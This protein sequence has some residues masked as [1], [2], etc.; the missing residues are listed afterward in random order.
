M[1]VFVG[2]RMH[3]TIAAFS[4]GV[5]TIPIA[6]SRKFEGLFGSLGYNHVIDITKLNT[7]QAFETIIREIKDYKV[8]KQDVDRGMII[9]EEKRLELRDILEKVISQV[10]END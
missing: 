9:A 10:K 1:D 2:A 6:Y 7:E 3:A 8:L 5:P 4:S